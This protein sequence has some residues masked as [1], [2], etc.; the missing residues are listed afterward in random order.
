MSPEAFL[1]LALSLPQTALGRHQAGPDL[2]VGGKIF[3]SP[4][5]RPGGTAVIKLTLEQREMLC[6]A[7]PDVF[8]PVEGMGASR[9]WT[10]VVVANADE[11]TA[12]SALWMAWRNVAPPKVARQVDGDEDRTAAAAL[13]PS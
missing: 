7:E 5:D 9:G 2:R 8:R 1:A 11:P 12:R 3:A 10:R 4:A 13:R 6:A